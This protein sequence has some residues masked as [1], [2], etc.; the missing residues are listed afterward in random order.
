MTKKQLAKYNEITRR[1]V[2]RLPVSAAETKWVWRMRPV[3]EL[4]MK[5]AS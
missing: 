2:R 4:M 3:Y 1:I 5:A